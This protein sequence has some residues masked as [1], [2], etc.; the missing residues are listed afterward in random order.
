MNGYNYNNPGAEGYG[1]GI[2]H[3]FSEESSDITSVPEFLNIASNSDGSAAIEII[4]A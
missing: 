3:I 2:Q 1:P 4:I